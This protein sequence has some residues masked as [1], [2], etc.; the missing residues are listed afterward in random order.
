[1][2]KE[3]IAIL[4]CIKPVNSKGV[5]TA[6]NSIYMQSVCC[7]QTPNFVELML[8]A[9]PTLH[10]L[11]KRHDGEEFEG[12]HHLEYEHLGYDVFKF[13]TCSCNYVKSHIS[14]DCKNPFFSLTIID[15]KATSHKVLC[16]SL[17]TTLT[18]FSH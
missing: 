11:W 17:N 16:H 2:I 13:H 14:L 15:E 4:I 18:S 10:I 6:Y 12:G 7:T 3:L 9:T 1:M 5:L 8:P